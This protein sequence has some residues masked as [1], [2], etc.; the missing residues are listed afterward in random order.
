MNVRGGKPIKTPFAVK[1]N[2]PFPFDSPAKKERLRP[3]NV[4]NP[5]QKRSEP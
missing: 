1:I 3:E 5:F 2:K 4:P